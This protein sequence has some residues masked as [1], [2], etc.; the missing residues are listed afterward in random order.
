M[1]HWQLVIFSLH[2]FSVV[3]TDAEK[4]KKKKKH[5]SEKLVNSNRTVDIFFFLNACSQKWLQIIHHAKVDRLR[6]TRAASR[7]ARSVDGLGRGG[8]VSC[9]ESATFVITSPLG[10]YLCSS[11]SIGMQ[12][13]R[14]KCI[15]PQ[16]RSWNPLDDRPFSFPLFLPGIVFVCVCTCV[17]FILSRAAE[18]GGLR[19]THAAR[20]YTANTQSPDLNQ[21]WQSCLL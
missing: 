11:W 19:W 8:V 10:C 17:S 6:W 2:V 7:F 13:R 21:E 3:M 12:S 15:H 16:Q 4:E 5:L 9:C 18:K 14:N 1:Q 20:P